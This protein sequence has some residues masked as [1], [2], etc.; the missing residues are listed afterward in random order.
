MSYTLN[1]LTV[2]AAA[3]VRYQ[4]ILGKLEDLNH[5]GHEGTRRTAVGDRIIGAFP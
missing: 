4:G 1:E 3:R 2:V 5:K